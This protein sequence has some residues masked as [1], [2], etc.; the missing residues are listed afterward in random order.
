MG[1][2]FSQGCL[3]AYRDAIFTASMVPFGWV[4]GAPLL[5]WLADQLGRRKP[6]LVVGILIMLSCLL[7]LAL[8][9]QVLP[10]WLTRSCSA[11]DREPQ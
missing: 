1:R 3:L 2:T 11:W 6:A 7:Q 9:P 5:G 8:A 4:I 10:S